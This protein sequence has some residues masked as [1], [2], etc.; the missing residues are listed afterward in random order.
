[1]D[2]HPLSGLHLSER[3]E[4]IVRSKERDGDRRR[5]FEAQVAWFGCNEPGIDRHVRRQAARPAGSNDFVA[6]GIFGNLIA[7]RDHPAG[8]FQAGQ[9]A[10]RWVRRDLRRKQPHDEH[11]VHEIEAGGGH[12]DLDL[13]GL[14]HRARDAASTQRIKNSR[15][16]HFDLEWWPVSPGRWPDVMRG[17]RGHR[18]QPVHV[19]QVAMQGDLV[20]VV[21]VA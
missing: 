5:L 1:M 2:Q 17:R 20:L 8:A 12:L 16:R 15:P 21:A 3:L 18:H 6:N 14:G 10:S 7:D 19:S 4:R 11:Q 9:V 13:I